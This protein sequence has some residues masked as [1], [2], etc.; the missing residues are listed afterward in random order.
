MTAVA[1]VMLKNMQQICETFGKSRRTI[2]KWRQEGA[3]IYKDGGV[4][5]AEVNALARW[6][7]EREAAL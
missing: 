5:G 2:L 3:P 6:L 7:V 1:P 4:Y